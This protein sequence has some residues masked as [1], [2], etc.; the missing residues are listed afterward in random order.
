MKYLRQTELE[1]NL[2]HLY[3]AQIAAEIRKAHVKD[4]Y[5]KVK[6]TDMVLKLKENEDAGENR[7]YTEEEKQEHINNSKHAWKSWLLASMKKTKP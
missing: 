4:G 5:K 3:L 7:P 2:N 1:T 6:I